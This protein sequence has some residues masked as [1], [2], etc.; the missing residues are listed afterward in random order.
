MFCV[1]ILKPL[2]ITR[3]L[4]LYF[5]LIAAFGHWLVM[6]WHTQSLC[7]H[8][9]RLLIS[10]LCNDII[11]PPVSRLTDGPWLVP[12]TPSAPRD[13]RRVT[14]SHP[15]PGPGGAG[16]APGELG[17]AQAGCPGSD[18][19]P[20]WPSLSLET[21]HNKR[22]LLLLVFWAPRHSPLTAEDLSQVGWYATGSG[23]F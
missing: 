8:V 23:S 11:T 17:P 7:L 18:H 16:P 15:S 14:E 6:T 10:L 20:V 21:R 3:P 9:A 2:E 4:S 5:L 13:Q 22:L 12:L 1:L 19:W